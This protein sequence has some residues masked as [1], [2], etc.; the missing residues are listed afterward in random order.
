M[1]NPQTENGYTPIPN[2]L[3]EA[4]S[5]YAPG[6]SQGQLLMAIL[7]KTIGWNKEK[8]ELSYSQLQ[9]TTGLSRRTIIYSL[10][11]LEAKHMITI[12]RSMNGSQLNRIGIQA[13]Y[14][15]WIPEARGDRYG[16]LL[17]KKKRRYQDK[18]IV[19]P[20][21]TIKEGIVAPVQTIDSR[22]ANKAVLP[23]QTIEKKRELFAPTKERK[24]LQKHSTKDT[25]NISLPDW[26][27]KDTWAAFLEIR[28]KK[29]IPSTEHALNLI[30]KEL[31]KF[32]DSGNEPNTVLE[33]SIMSGWTGVF[34]L[35]DGGRNDGTH[36]RN[37]TKL[38]DRNSYTKPPPNPKLE[39]LVAEAR[40][41][42]EKS[43]NNQPE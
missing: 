43:G 10:Q 5:R 21:Q 25:C 4:F 32:K 11:N 18:G 15:Q 3:L 36:Q 19:A 35:K 27:D 9:E 7:R 30:I 24:T 23:V 38:P 39:R 14:E 17:S 22:G 40:A 16:G 1:A 8:D 26:L 28:K 2:E 42:R 6:Y 12:E 34:P 41:A 31:G 37:S 29:K 20:V 13:D 33:K